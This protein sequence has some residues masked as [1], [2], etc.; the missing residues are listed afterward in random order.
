MFSRIFPAFLLIFISGLGLGQPTPGTAPPEGDAASVAEPDKAQAP[1]ASS[2]KGG[3][4][5][6]GYPFPALADTVAAAQNMVHAMSLRDY[7][8]NEKLSDDFVR[9][10]LALFSRITGREEDCQSVL[11]YMR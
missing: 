11:D 6:S 1:D 3:R 4:D 5:T 10:R 7:C 2:G 9:G 8:A